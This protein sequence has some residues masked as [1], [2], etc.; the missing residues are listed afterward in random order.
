MEI[1]LAFILYVTLF[2]LAIIAA[3]VIS[4][5]LGYRLFCRGV[6]PEAKGRDGTAVEAKLGGS[7]FTLKNAAP[8]T[9]FALFGVLIISL[10][11]VKGSPEFTL[12]VL[13]TAGLMQEIRETRPDSQRIR[14]RGKEKT[15]HILTQEGI[16]FENKGETDRAIK[17]YQEAVAL[18]AT[19]MNHLAWQYQRQGKF[20]E[21]LSLAR[22][23]VQLKPD[24]AQ[25]LDTLA[26]ILCKLGQRPEA[27]RY[28]EKA[29]TL[30]P[31]EFASKLEAFKSGF[32][33]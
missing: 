9:C 13:N 5:F 11:F 31:Q 18:M 1:P 20:D 7:S 28:M 3:G 8:G 23:A 29:A 27:V 12:E 33:E 6:W 22:L 15:L 17:S 4:I 16:A 25:F 2:R 19:P 26:V 30:N 21:A 14:I 32:C 24:E 10:T